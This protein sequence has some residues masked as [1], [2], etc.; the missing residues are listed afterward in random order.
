VGGHPLAAAFSLLL[1]PL[2]PP[3][4]EPVD[5]VAVDASALPEVTIDIVAP[6]RFSAE[7]ITAA[8]IDVDGAAVDSVTAIDPEDI[9]VGLVIDDRPAIAPAVVTKLQGAA[10]ELVR[11]SLSGIEVSLG[12]PSG[13]RTALTADRE[14]TIARVSGITAGSP[15]VVPL[16]DV[17]TDTVAE[18]ATSTST[19]RH[20]VVVLGGAADTA[21][22]ELAGIRDA[23]A[24]SGTVLH[25]VA[26]TTS[27]AEAFSRLAE[28]SGGEVSTSP[29]VLA[30][31]DDVT[32]M[33]SNRYRVVANVAGEGPH[34]IGLALGG[35]RFSAEFDVPSTA[36]APRGS[37]PPETRPAQSRPTSGSAPGTA[38]GTAVQ[39]GTGTVT[40]T[41]PQ[42]LEVAQPAEDGGLPTKSILL[43]ALALA[44][45]VLVAAG[46]VILV[47]RR[48]GGEDDDEPYV[49][50][51]PAD[52]PAAPKPVPKPV[53]RPPTKAV[54][55]TK[56]VSRPAPKPV[57]RPPTKAVTSTKA[58]SRPAPKPAVSRP[59]TKA[60]PS[61]NV[62]AR[63]PQR[64]TP[65]P[66]NGPPR[67]QPA[68]VT[69]LPRRSTRAA[70]PPPRRAVEP[71]PPAQPESPVPA[72]QSAEWI[73]AGDL[74]VDRATGE[75]WS[76][77]H[78]VDLTPTELR[79]LELLITNA[80]HGV[81][82]EALVEAGELDEGGGPDAVDA[83]V[84]QVRRKT[85]IRGRGHAVRKERVVTYFLE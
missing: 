7:P 33:I 29:E 70:T 66:T 80:E 8:S 11:N 39:Q 57:P 18:L 25:V 73:A 47:R 67:R 19:D 58:V 85:G 54:T 65:G 77:D 60:A 2:A 76:G 43:A 59:V 52:A 74:R 36:P 72:G 21:D 10:V 79:V 81:T 34:E 28:R 84:T 14:A 68:A 45:V 26:P 9:V 15:A 48:T 12:T 37:A 16:T 30:A 23:L 49:L 3:S 71:P 40:G 17:V 13:L 53:P 24:A 55:S 22:P 83:I 50:K 1:V 27:D 4:A 51:K 64:P 6:V 35:Q 78:K 31:V 56:A 38:P 42:P 5:V 20:A 44:V 82:R 69:P 41:S 61:A 62:A 46:V 63:A 32:A 75:V